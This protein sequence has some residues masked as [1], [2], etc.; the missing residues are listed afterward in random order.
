VP[1]NKKGWGKKKKK[2]IELQKRKK[3]KNNHRA[4]Q[5]KAGVQGGVR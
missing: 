2:K 4:A 3:T 5:G 1:K